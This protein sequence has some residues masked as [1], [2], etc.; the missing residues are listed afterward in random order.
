MGVIMDAN[1]TQ[2]PSVSAKRARPG[3]RTEKNRQAV[4]AAVLDLIQ[5]GRLDFEVQEVAALSG[6]HRTTIFRRWPDRGALL[7]EALAQHVSRVS[8]PL[9]G[10]WREDLRR[11]AYGMRD[12]LCDPVELAM[13]RLLVQKGGAQFHEQ[14]L[15]QWGATIAEFEQPFTDAKVRGEL[16][17]DVDVEMM[18]DS[19]LAVIF[20]AIT[21]RQTR[22]ADSDLDRLIDQTI[23]GCCPP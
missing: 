5:Q 12:F 15:T 18:I 23:R 20:Y 14:M 16:A 21:I 10:T 4:A 6:V 1:T 7:A 17:H 3:G 11:I 9:S 22:P 8:I 2:S 19:L 13:N